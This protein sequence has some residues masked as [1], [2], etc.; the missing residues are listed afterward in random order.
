MSDNPPDIL[1]PTLTNRLAMRQRPAGTP[2][3]HQQWGDLLFMHWPVPVAVLQPYLPPRL[4]LDTYDGMAWLAVVPFRMWDV[5]TRFTPPLPGARDFLE[6]NVRTYVHLDGVP[7]VWFLSLDA[8]N[9]LAVWAARTFFH[10]P[11]LRANH[12]ANPPCARR[13]ASR[14][15]ADAHRGAVRSFSGHLGRGR[16][17]APGGTGLTGLFP[18]RTLLPLRR[19]CGRHPAVARPDSPRAV[20]A[21]KCHPVALRVVAAGR[22]RAAHARWGTSATRGPSRARGAVAVAAGVIL[23]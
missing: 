13:V 20:A 5:H 11:Y 22:P 17:L 18:H 23:G 9:A 6:L 14:S 15:H 2:L 3:M 10:L 4:Q 7:G 12:A 1:T 16:G 19:Q 21:G 8:S